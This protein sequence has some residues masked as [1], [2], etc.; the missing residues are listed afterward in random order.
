[1][2]QEKDKINIDKVVL[3]VGDELYDRAVAAYGKIAKVQKHNSII[4]GM[5]FSQAEEAVICLL[6]NGGLEREAV[7]SDVFASPYGL[8]IDSLSDKMLS[9]MSN[10]AEIAM[11][12]ADYSIVD[13]PKPTHPIKPKQR[14]KKQ[15]IP[16]RPVNTYARDKY[17]R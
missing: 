15:P 11:K 16:A 13:L 7:A 3:I 17:R 9:I 5:D 1:M 6:V 14:A 4:V 10:N 8:V 2:T 12:A